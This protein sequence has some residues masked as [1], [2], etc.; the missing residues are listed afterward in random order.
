MQKVHQ[1]DKLGTLLTKLAKN[2]Y[3][4]FYRKNMKKNDV[5]I[6]LGVFING[7][8]SDSTSSYDDADSTAP[9]VADLPSRKN[10]QI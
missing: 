4:D 9:L 3:L 5:K 1:Q 2:P 6:F 10:T 7:R 8:R